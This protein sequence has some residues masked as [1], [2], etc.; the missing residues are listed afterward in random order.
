VAFDVPLVL[1]IAD[2]A[3]LKLDAEDNIRAQGIVEETGAN[4]AIRKFM[5]SISPVKDCES[6]GE[7]NNYWTHEK[8]TLNFSKS[9]RFSL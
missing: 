1:K 4:Y 2:L 5:A 7:C 9:R 6:C 8:C 3:V